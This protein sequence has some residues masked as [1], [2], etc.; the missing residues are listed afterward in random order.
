MRVGI[1]GYGTLGRA[2]HAGL[3]THDGVR[4]VLTTRRGGDN[5][6]LVVQSDVVMLCVKPYHMEGVAREIAPELNGRHVLITTATGIGA[7]QVRDWT[8][9]ASPVVRTMP[10]MPVRSG[11]GMTV[12]ARD[13]QSNDDAIR[14]AESLF[15]SIGLTAIMDERLMAAA[16]AISGCGP[17]YGY[18]IIEALTDAG[19]KLGIPYETARLLVAQ[20]LF[21]AARM[22]LD[23][24]AHPAALKTEVTTPAGCTIDGLLELEDGKLRSTLMRAVIS[25]ARTAEALSAPD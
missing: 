20:T 22:V 6:A 14:V 8:N 18:L 15:A 13:A 7:S 4:D 24:D 21:G 1:I 17:A 16:T 3:R 12:I 2:I 9:G 11:A 19:I 5:R 25:A 23:G 10:N